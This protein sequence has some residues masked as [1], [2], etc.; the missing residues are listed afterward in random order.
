MWI[1]NYVF[2]DPKFHWAAQTTKK[3]MADWVFLI[4]DKQTVSSSYVLWYFFSTKLCF[5]MLNEKGC[6]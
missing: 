6:G 1:K 3:L 2:N 5:K 4:H